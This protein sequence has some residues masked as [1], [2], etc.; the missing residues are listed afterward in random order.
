MAVPDE[1]FGQRPQF[2]DVLL[3]EHVGTGGH[4]ADQRHVADGPA[5]GGGA[6]CRVVAHLDR[7]RLGRVAAQIAEALEG[8]EMGVHGGRRRQPHGRADL[9]D[10]GWV[11]PGAHVLL[12]DVEDRQLAVGEVAVGHTPP[13][14]RCLDRVK[15]ARSPAEGKHLF[16]FSLDGNRRS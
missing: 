6:R 14:N 3:G 1:V 12:D 13:P 2:L 15:V 9:T 4:L 7:S 16:V 8:A 5:L 10:R 11:A